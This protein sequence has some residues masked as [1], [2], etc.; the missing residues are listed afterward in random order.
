[1]TVYVDDMNRAGRLRG[2]LVRWSHLFA[3]TSA[4]LA[5]AAAALGLDPAWVQHPGTHR[6]HYDVVASVRARALAAGAKPMR[7]PHEVGAFF[8]ARRD[9]RRAGGGS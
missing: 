1:M 4:E 8:A 2:R 7:Y 9:D 3:D 6:E 5:D